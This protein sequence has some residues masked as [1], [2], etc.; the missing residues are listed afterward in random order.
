MLANTSRPSGISIISWIVYES[1]QYASHSESHYE[2][3]YAVHC[4]CVPTNI[5]VNKQ[6]IM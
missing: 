1:S 3:N 5:Q 2:N 6:V 4:A